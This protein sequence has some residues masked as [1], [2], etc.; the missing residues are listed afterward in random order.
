MSL[1]SFIS[2]PEV[3]E[4][5]VEEFPLPTA[6]LRGAMAAPIVTKNYATSWAPRPNT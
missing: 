1:T 3:K 5:F 6:S 4:R 2:I